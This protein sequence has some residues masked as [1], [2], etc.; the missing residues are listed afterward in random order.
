M[1]LIVFVWFLI[2]LKELLRAK[3]IEC[4]WRDQLKALC[5]GKNTSQISLK[6]LHMFRGCFV[7]QPH[8]FLF[9]CFAEV[10]KEKGIENVTVEDLVAGVT[11][12]GRGRPY[13]TVHPTIFF[14]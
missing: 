7:K 9:V 10:I 4:G 8:C 6:S 2:R 13:L 3:L 11:P 14:I 12:K 1:N 5:K